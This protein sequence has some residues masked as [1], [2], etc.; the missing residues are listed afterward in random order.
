MA[1]TRTGWRRWYDRWEAQQESFNPSREARFSA[2]LDALGAS[3]PARFRALDLGSGPGGLSVRLLRRFPRATCVA[4]DYDP[5]V[6]RVGRGAWGSMGGRLS[7][8][9][10][11]LGSPGWSDRLPRGRY[12]AAVSTTALHWLSGAA[13]PGFYRELGR[14]L[15]RGAVFLDGDRLAYGPSEPALS[16][17]AEKV[18]RRRFTGQSLDDEW[19]AWRLWWR[20]AE[21]DA[22]LRK[23]FPE[24]ELRQSQHPAHG[25]EPLDAH[26]GALR[27][28]GFG[29]PAVVWRDLENCVLFARR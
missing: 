27:R 19:S 29:A 25:D 7:W 12:D 2:L 4:V 18:R 21:R 15:R 24:R 23:L 6:Q 28:A 10:A 20:S 22:E 26:V 17:L 5:V 9:D 3:L 14:T 11:N 13:L 1:R 8:V 16:R